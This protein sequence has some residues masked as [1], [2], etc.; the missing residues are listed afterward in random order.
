MGTNIWTNVDA[1]HKALSPVFDQEPIARSLLRQQRRW[2]A[3]SRS[4]VW[5]KGI[6]AALTFK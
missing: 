3:T 6:R 1:Y 4:K 5:L 2:V